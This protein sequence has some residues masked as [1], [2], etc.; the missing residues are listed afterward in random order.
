MR[1]CF[2]SA[3][4]KFTEQRE[5][6]NN[7]S[8]RQKKIIVYLLGNTEIRTSK[9]AKLLRV[10]TDTALRELGILL[11]QRKIEKKGIGRAVHYILKI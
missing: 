1:E 10:S 4:S 5:K 2:Y 6:K 11:K 9:C 7:L 3:K 8:E